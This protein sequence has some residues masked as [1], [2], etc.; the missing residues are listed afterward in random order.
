LREAGVSAEKID[1]VICPLGLPIGGN[2]PEEIAISIAAQLLERRDF[3][4]K[5][6]K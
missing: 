4:R 5:D 2:A 1:R 6:L 3:L